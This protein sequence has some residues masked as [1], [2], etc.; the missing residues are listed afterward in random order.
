MAWIM[1]LFRSISRLGFERTGGTAAYSCLH[2]FLGVVRRYSLQ[3]G[4]SSDICV[5]GTVRGVSPFAFWR[6]RLFRVYLKGRGLR[7]RSF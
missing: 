4:I 3:T 2:V 7:K 5:L 6:R 1:A